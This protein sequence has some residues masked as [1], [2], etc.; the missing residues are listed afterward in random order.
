MVTGGQR[1]KEYVTKGFENRPVD[2]KVDCE[3]N[4]IPAHALGKR[5]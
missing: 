3:K 1:E 2:Q 4:K 5:K